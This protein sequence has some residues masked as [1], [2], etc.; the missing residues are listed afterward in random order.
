M[1]DPVE[2]K[3]PE[4]MKGPVE[5]NDPLEQLDHCGDTGSSEKCRMTTQTESPC[6]SYNIGE[7]SQ[8]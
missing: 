3:N 2:M 4:V 7:N 6:K 1:K 5:I 8:P